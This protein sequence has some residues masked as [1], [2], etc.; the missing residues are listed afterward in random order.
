MLSRSVVLAAADTL[1]LRNLTLRGVKTDC[2]CFRFRLF[3]GRPSGVVTRE[4]L[5]FVAATA[6]KA[7]FGAFGAMAMAG[8]NDIAAR[9][10]IHYSSI[11]IGQEI[12]KALAARHEV[13]A[14]RREYP[15]L[16]I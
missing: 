5:S 4:K 8:G 1:A 3:C 11:Y 16:T 2:S 7:R 10:G 9:N 13:A 12:A 14:K 15:I 6:H